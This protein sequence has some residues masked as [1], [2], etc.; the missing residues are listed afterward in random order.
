M[1]NYFRDR[2]DKNLRMDKKKQGKKIWI[3]KMFYGSNNPILHH[4]LIP[5]KLSVMECIDWIG[6]GSTWV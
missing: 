2:E 5:D 1:P 3:S 4:S 6:M